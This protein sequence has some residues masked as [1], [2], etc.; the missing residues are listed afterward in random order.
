[1][2]YPHWYVPF[3]TAPMLIP[4]VAIPHVVVAQLAVGGGFLLADL[5][6]RAYRASDPGLLAYLRRF[7]RFFILLTV[8]F[9]AVTGVGIWWTIGLTSPEA[10][11][12]LIHV[13][14]FGWATEWVFFVLEIVSAFAF[15]YLWDRLPPREHVALGWVYAFSAWMSLVLITGITAFM[16]TSGSWTPE[17]SFFVAFFNPSFV[18]QVLIRTGGSL[19]IA[20]LGVGLHAA[21][22]AD[23]AWK[24]R[25]VRWVSRW[26]LGGMVCIGLGTL[27][28][29]LV[30]PDHARLNMVRAPML[31][32]M[33]ALNFGVTLVVIAALALGYVVGHRWVT[34]PSAVLLFM[35]G[36]LAITTGEFIRE[37]SRKPYQIERY[38]LS[39]G[40]RVSNVPLYHEQGF[41]ART[42]WPAF[43]LRQRWPDLDPG[44]PD[45]WTD[46]QQV[47]VGEAIFRYH[48]AGCH[49][50][51][52]YNGIRPI[53]RPWTPE[54]IREA[55]R[56]LHRTNP[57]MP[58]W[59][60]NEAEREAL[61]R[62]LVHLQ[63]ASA[64]S[65][66]P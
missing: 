61:A 6:R 31:L 15:Y 35:A 64:G 27:G 41:I 33:T 48:C 12:A 8:V 24:D 11:S 63:E 59:L 54:L 36:V 32:T 26:A 43:Y 46:D 17:K 28:Y 34:P 22:H 42:P 23:G 7:A 29:L 10:T 1:M 14:V 40:V 65:M 4:L 66:A 45:R 19:A 47:H 25:L 37:G 52:G 16:L 49:A 58:P 30:L 18:P 44:R 55:V 62:Y 51:T 21:F 38:I 2:E 53:I 56:H 39:P 50:L 9:G 3:L 60:G 5:T 20:A 13:F 57:A